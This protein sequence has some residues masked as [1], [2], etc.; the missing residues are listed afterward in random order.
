VKKKRRSDGPNQIH[1]TFFIASNYDDGNA[2]AT[3]A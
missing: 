3:T 1:S 2:I